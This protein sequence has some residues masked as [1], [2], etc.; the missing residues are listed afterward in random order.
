LAGEKQII[1]V[2]DSTIFGLK[3]K[4]GEIL[5]HYRHGGGNNTTNPII[6]GEDKIFIKHSFNGSMMLKVSK[7]SKE[8]QV[9][10]IWQNGNIRS[11]LAP[12]IAHNGYLYGYVNRIFTCV[13]AETGDSVWKSRQP[14]PGFSILIDN[15]LVILTQR[16]TM[17]IAEASPEGY[18]EVAATTVFTGQTYTPPSFAYGSIYAR[19]L[20]EIARV[21]IARVDEII[22]QDTKPAKKGLLPESKFAAFVANVEKA[23]NRKSMIDNFMS[24]QKQF[25]IIEGNSMAHIVYRGELNDIVLRG[26]F[27]PFGTQ[28]PMNRIADSDLYYYSVKLEPDA[29]VAYQFIKDFGTAGEGDPRNSNSFNNVTPYTGE[30]G[31]IYMPKSGDQSYL[32]DPQGLT[33][34]KIDTFHF[35]SAIMEV[36]RKIEV[37]LPPGYGNGATRYP[38][39]Y[40]NYGRRMKDWG[41]MPNALDNLIGK[42]ISP[43]V[44]IFIHVNPKNSFAEVSGALK[45]KYAQMVAEELVPHIDE[46]YRTLANPDARTIMGGSSGGIVSVLAALGHPGV[47]GKVACQSLNLSNAANNTQLT[48]LVKD[49][50]K[51]PVEFF[52]HWGKYDLGNS[53]FSFSALNRTFADVLQENGYSNHGGELNHGFG[54]PSWSAFTDDILERF[55]PLKTTEK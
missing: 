22:A 55:Y 15:H 20:H 25:P 13:D 44:A 33:R 41:K 43:V 38:T 12:T 21:D 14:G 19:N 18:K 1:S 53:F 35:E 8:Y 24:S 52:L 2:G 42:T 6:V 11:A 16:G 51:Q 40:V 47:F 3:P 7:S 28:D 36:S 32:K 4:T 54:I 50:D 30:N 23:T 9:E 17:H 37:Y 45:E 31:V 5:W 26:D 34:G 29:V 46:K 27:V 10:Q 39:V 48:N 49:S